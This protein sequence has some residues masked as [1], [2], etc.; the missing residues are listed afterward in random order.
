MTDPQLQ[1]IWAKQKALM[2]RY[3][4]KGS[5]PEYPLELDSQKAQNLMRDFIARYAEELCE[6]LEQY[7]EATNKST[8]TNTN[9]PTKIPTII[10]AALEEL[11]DALHFIIEAMIYAEIDP[12][13]NLENLIATYIDK[14]KLEASWRD[15]LNMF[16]PVFRGEFK[17]KGFKHEEQFQVSL[18]IE[19]QVTM[20]IT[21]M[22]AIKTAFISRN[23]LKI[24]DWRQADSNI[25]SFKVSLAGAFFEF[26]AITSIMQIPPTLMYELY[27]TKN[28]INIQRIPQ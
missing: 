14:Y 15:I 21:V 2:N 3:I 5:L 17:Y 28:E 1:E 11:A 18:G 13:H 8:Y 10:D 4:E 23:H 16:K 25:E 19:S 6:F 22:R 9:A 12:A 26:M 20:Q 27:L 24:R 7:D